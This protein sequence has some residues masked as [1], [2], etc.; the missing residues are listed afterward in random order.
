MWDDENRT[1]YELASRGSEPE[2]MKLLFSRDVVY[3][4]RG[5]IF[6]HDFRAGHTPQRSAAANNLSN[7]IYCMSTES[8]FHF[9]TISKSPCVIGRSNAKGVGTSSNVN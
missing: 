6:S 2:I 3:N 1:A 8:L 9:H 7:E 4:H 5:V